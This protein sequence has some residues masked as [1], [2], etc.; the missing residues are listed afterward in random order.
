MFFMFRVIQHHDVNTIQIIT[1]QLNIQI[2][3][4]H[5]SGYNIGYVS[6]NIFFFNLGVILFVIVQS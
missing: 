4:I 6:Q 2:Q 3:K 5:E 1:K